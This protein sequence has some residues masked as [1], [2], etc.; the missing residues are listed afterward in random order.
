MDKSEW[1]EDEYH[2]VDW[3]TAENIRFSVE[4]IFLPENKKRNFD[5]WKQQLILAKEHSM[6]P[7][8]ICSLMKTTALLKFE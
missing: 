7:K 5:S 4:N 1:A 8:T 3:L 6:A 2:T